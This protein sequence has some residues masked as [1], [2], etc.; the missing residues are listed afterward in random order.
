MM[1]KNRLVLRFP[2]QTLGAQIYVSFKPA[3]AQLLIIN[4]KSI[5][6]KTTTNQIKLIN[7]LI[8]RMNQTKKNKINKSFDN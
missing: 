6:K 4:K 8:R 1:M 2:L 7:I 5:F 3:E